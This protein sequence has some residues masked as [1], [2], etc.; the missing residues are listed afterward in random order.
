MKKIA[1]GI[2]AIVALI[3]VPALA[4]D[5]AM[6][7]PPTPA[8]PPAP[9]YSW[10]GFYVGANVGGGWSNDTGTI[11][12]FGPLTTI[13]PFT[14]NLGGAAALVGF[15]EGI[16]WQ[17]APTW[18]V[19]IEGDWS[20]LSAGH[21]LSQS[22]TFGGGTPSPFSAGSLGAKL[23]WL[24][25]ARSRLGYLVT[26]NLMAYGTGGVA[27]GKIA[28]AGAASLNN[29]TGFT[30]SSNVG[31]NDVSV[32]WV[33]GGGLEWMFAPHWLLRG[34]YLFYHLNS[35]QGMASNNPLA[36]GGVCIIGP[37]CP[38]PPDATIH[39]SWSDMLAWW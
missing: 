28:Y 36:F 1:I 16:N 22:L 27:F 32:G 12:F 31:F 14:G 9:V 11:S 30:Y 15:Q 26:P 24:A 21:P 8:P 10:T 19:G 6:K 4:A 3:A 13:D 17:F 23:D 38:P 20:Y 37:G 5:M 2:A 35:P 39:Y 18:V 33:A 25:S 7:A 29:P 34:E